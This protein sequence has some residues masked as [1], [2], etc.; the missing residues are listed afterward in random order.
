MSTEAVRPYK[1]TSLGAIQQT[2]DAVQGA[3]PRLT[4]DGCREVVCTIADA[5]GSLW[6]I[7]GVIPSR[8]GSHATADFIEATWPRTSWAGPE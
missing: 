8:T 1:L 7:A 3:L 4:P 5:A 6:Q 2:T